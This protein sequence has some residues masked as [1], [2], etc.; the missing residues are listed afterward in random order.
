[1]A[2]MKTQSWIEAQRDRHHKL[3]VN[4]ERSN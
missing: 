4:W 2:I 1:M 3:G